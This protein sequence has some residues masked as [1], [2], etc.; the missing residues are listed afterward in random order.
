[1][2]LRRQVRNVSPCAEALVSLPL[3]VLFMFISQRLERHVLSLFEG[4][5]SPGP[6]TAGA[7]LGQTNAVCARL[8]NIK[9]MKPM[10]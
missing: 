1:M 8:G 7:A 3:L 10:T 6:S 4:A 2:S 5:A 9:V